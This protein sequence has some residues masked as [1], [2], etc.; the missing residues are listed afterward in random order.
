MGWLKS[1][2]CGYLSVLIILGW[3]GCVLSVETDFVVSLP[4]LITPSIEKAEKWQKTKYFKLQVANH[5][6]SPFAL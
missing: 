2:V 4:N 1:S 3:Y 6:Q 5:N